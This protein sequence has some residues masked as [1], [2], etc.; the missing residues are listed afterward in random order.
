MSAMINDVRFIFISSCLWEGLCL[1][2]VILCLF[3]H[4][5]VQ[6]IL[7]CVLFSPSSCIPYVASLSG[8]S[9]FVALSSFSNVYMH[10]ISVNY[11]AF[12]EFMV[13]HLSQFCL[14]NVVNVV[15]SIPIVVT[16][17]FK[18]EKYWFLAGSVLLIFKSFLCCVFVLFASVLC[19][20][21]F[22]CL[23][24]VHSF[25]YKHFKC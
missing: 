13:Y 5:G 22:Q 24:I 7:W 23:W 9:I 17:F 20:E 4:S 10:A 16:A 11:L 21:C 14:C 3:A 19:T 8:L 6:H 2:Y 12:S 25:I 18:L 15:F 1:F